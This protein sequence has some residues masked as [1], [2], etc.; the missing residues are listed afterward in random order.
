[1]ATANLAALALS[2][3]RDLKTFADTELTIASGAVTKTRTSHNIDTESNAASD[4]LDTI[5]GGVEGDFLILT[6]NN[7]ARTV[8]V[9]HNTGNIL[10][11][12]ATDI[13]LAEDDDYALLY[14]TGAKWVVVGQKLTAGNTGSAN[15]GA[16]T[17]IDFSG[18]PASVTINPTG[19]GKL[20]LELDLSNTGTASAA[21]VA[22][23]WNGN[24]TAT[25]YRRQQDAGDGGGAVVNA[26][27][28]SNVLTTCGTDALPS[29][30]RAW[31]RVEFPNFDDTT[32]PKQAFVSMHYGA[33]TG[34]LGVYNQ[35][36]KRTTGSNLNAA[37]TSVTFAAPTGT[38]STACKGRWRV[39]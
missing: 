23:T 10:C 7:D 18:A 1:M 9:K 14:Y 39:E 8:V 19:S 15:T 36:V 26:G 27:N 25:E 5:N 29:G 32:Q 24:T 30:S 17:A 4:D 28:D 37:I 2:G 21:A 35:T 33:S 11:P 16:W 6:A 31:Q 13:S 3:Q 34:S 22:I 38:W 12:G 20:V